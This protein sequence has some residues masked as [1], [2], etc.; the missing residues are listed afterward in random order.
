MA[1]T[2]DIVTYGAMGFGFVFFLRI[3]VAFYP[4]L[5][6]SLSLI[7]VFYEWDDVGDVMVPFLILFVLI[8]YLQMVLLLNIRYLWFIAIPW[9]LISIYPFI[10]WLQWIGESNVPFPGVDWMP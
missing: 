5:M 10:K 4:S 1:K 6:L 8:G 3:V 9:F 7:N 2:G